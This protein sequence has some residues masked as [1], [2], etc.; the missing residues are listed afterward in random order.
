V[1]AGG[2]RYHQ[3]GS[4]AVGTGDQDGV[5]EPCCL[6]IEQRAET[7]QTGVRAR[8]G[9]GARERLDRVDQ[10]VAGIDI[11]PGILVGQM[12]SAR[13]GVLRP[14]GVLRR[15]VRGSMVAAREKYLIRDALQ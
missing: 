13:Y 7:A 11:D 15:H 9:G 10:A 3:L 8:A 5:L 4:D 12:I 2:Q 6:E 1:L 14:L